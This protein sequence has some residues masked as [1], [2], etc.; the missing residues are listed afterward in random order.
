MISKSYAYLFT[1]LAL[2]CTIESTFSVQSSNL[3][4][5][6]LEYF[7]YCSNGTCKLITGDYF[8]RARDMP[9]DLNVSCKKNNQY[10]LTF[11]DG[12]SNNYPRLLEILKRNNVKAT[13]FIVGSR[14]QNEEAL[15]W[16]RQA[17]ADGHFMAN[18]TYN[19]DDLT[20]FNE[21]KMV[22]TIEK[23]RDAM[24]RAIYPDAQ[25]RNQNPNKQRLEASSK[26]VRPPF[27]NINMEVDTIFKNHGYTSV[28]WNAD[29]YDWDMPGND[30]RTTETILNRV[31]QQL[32]YIASE[33]TSGKVFNHSVLDLNHDWQPTTVN[34]IQDL[35]I[36]VKSRG[37][38]FVTLDECLGSS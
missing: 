4:T 16:F 27:G 19:H 26:V 33:S 12:P 35:I 2:T 9:V 11:D 6:N 13:F 10:A 1:L 17:V 30:S 7:S 36:F 24:I 8:H 3:H 22:A 38:K 14:L 37:Y 15:Q 21:E 28:R 20:T 18:H 31:R 23:T 5:N 29:R 25:V 34:A 32:D